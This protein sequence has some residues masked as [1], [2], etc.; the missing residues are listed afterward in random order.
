[1]VLLEDAR[2]PLDGAQ[3]RAEVV[4]DSRAE[5]AAAASISFSRRSSRMRRFSSSNWRRR[6]CAR[7][8][9]R[10]TSKSLDFEM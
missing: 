1:V 7:T 10:R 4:R 6:T 2:E 5:R 3:R 8:R 9:A